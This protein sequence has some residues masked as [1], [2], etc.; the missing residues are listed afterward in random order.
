MTLK[1]EKALER[2]F[3]WVIGLA[4]MGLISWATWA[5][6][7]SIKHESRISVVETRTDNIYDS[8]KRLEDGQKDIGKRIDKLSE[9]R[10]DGRVRPTQ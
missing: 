7:T 10:S 8:L 2:A 4:L 5:T 3:G 6:A 9:R 1:T